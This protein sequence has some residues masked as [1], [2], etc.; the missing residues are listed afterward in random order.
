MMGLGL[1]LDLNLQ[2]SSSATYSSGGEGG[3]DT[4]R[5]E[6]ATSLAKGLFSSESKRA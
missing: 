5:R 3:S 2:N 6:S 4:E 1:K